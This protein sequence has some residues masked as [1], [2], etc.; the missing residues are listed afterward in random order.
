MVENVE[1]FGR[2]KTRLS[3]L[4]FGKKYDKNIKEIEKEKYET[5]IKTR[6][7]KKWYANEFKLTIDFDKTDTVLEE[8]SKFINEVSKK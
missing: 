1:F 8:I 2:E 7:L 3:R 6:S 5:Y 4:F